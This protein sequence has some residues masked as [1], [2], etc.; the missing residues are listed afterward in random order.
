[1]NEIMEIRLETLTMS[2]SRRLRY[3]CHV[4]SECPEQKCETLA[5]WARWNAWIQA[6]LPKTLDLKFMLIAWTDGRVVKAPA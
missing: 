4:T 6:P 5:D 2:S 3:K 1:M